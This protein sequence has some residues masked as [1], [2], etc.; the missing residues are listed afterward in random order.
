MAGICC[1]KETDD[2]LDS[3]FDICMDYTKTPQQRKEKVYND[4]VGKL[5]SSYNSADQISEFLDKEGGKEWERAQDEIRSHNNYGWATMVI[6]MIR[7]MQE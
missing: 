5:V 6:Q 7:N 2:L 1:G 4:V 3:I